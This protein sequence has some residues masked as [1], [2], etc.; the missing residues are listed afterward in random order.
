[1]I[2]FSKNM[3]LLGAALALMSVEEPWPAS[4]G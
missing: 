1:M 3:A 2:H 4:L